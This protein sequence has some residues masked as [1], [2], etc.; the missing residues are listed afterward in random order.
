MEAIHQTLIN[1]PWWVYV[2]FVYLISLG[3]KASKTRVIPFFKLLVIPV[4][5]GWMAVHAWIYQIGVTPLT[6][7]VFLI[8]NLITIILGWVYVY[9]QKLRV[10]KAHMLIETPGTWT[11]M[12]VILLIFVSKYYCGYRM[13]VDPTIVKNTY[14]DA[15]FLAVSGLCTGYFI[16]RALCWLYRLFTSESVDL[17]C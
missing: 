6:T 11:T 17:S 10:D 7:K 4:L 2:L 16:G 15:A 13:G 12:L 5:F 9:R 14:F 8:S 3:I 1:T